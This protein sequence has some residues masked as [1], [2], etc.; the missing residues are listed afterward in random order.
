LAVAAIPSLVY[1]QSPFLIA[2]QSSSVGQVPAVVM[3]VRC[4]VGSLNVGAIAAHKSTTDEPVGG[5]VVH[6]Q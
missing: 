4:F 5:K 2:Y 1:Y 3:Q 6:Y